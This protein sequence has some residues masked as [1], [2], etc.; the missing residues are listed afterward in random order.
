MSDSEE[1]DPEQDNWPED[2]WLKMD[3]VPDAPWV[4]CAGKLF[5][6]AD[7]VPP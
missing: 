7:L 1:D 5:L 3:E 6:L 2:K 4:T